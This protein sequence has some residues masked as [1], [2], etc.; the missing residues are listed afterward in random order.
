M[1]QTK[2]PDEITVDRPETPDYITKL[3][4][5]MMKKDPTE[6]FQTCAEIESAVTFCQQQLLASPPVPFAT[7]LDQPLQTPQTTLFNVEETFKVGSSGAGAESPGL[8]STDEIAAAPIS[9]EP[10]QLVPVSPFAV[11]TDEV[12]PKIVSGRPKLPQLTER[13]KKKSNI[14][15]WFGLMFGAMLIFLILAVFIATRFL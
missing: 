2:E 1:H 14:G 15:L 9:P 8:L 13:K 3:C 4:K 6:R 12:K 7:S 11:V 10:P 5:R